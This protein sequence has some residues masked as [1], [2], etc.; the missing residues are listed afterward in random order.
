MNTKRT[1]KK[2]GNKPKKTTA[3]DLI[4]AQAKEVFKALPT[5]GQIKAWLKEDKHKRVDY[6]TARAIQARLKR[7]GKKDAKP[8]EPANV[9]DPTEDK[10]TDVGA[11]TGVPGARPAGQMRYTGRHG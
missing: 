8:V 9:P 1:T 3:M 10:A 6:T 4:T 11:I 7:A 2:T 5:P